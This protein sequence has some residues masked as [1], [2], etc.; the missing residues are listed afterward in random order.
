MAHRRSDE[1]REGAV[2]G[3][4]LAGIEV[5]ELL[6][7]DHDWLLAGYLPHLL[8]AGD[9]DCSVH[10]INVWVRDVPRGQRPA[11][12]G[13]TDGRRSGIELLE[14]IAVLVIP[15]GNIDRA[16]KR[17]RNIEATRIVRS[18][19]DTGRIEDHRLPADG[20]GAGGLARGLCARDQRPGRENE[21]GQRRE[22][23]SKP[24]CASHVSSPFFVDMI[25]YRGRA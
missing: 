23:K 6:A 12:G 10:E 18:R 8:H 2:L 25:G 1:V 19:Y 3:D 24:E 11:V 21:Q 4:D 7:R 5:N 15:L 13:E 17:E 9:F 16:G 14:E 22:S 20:A